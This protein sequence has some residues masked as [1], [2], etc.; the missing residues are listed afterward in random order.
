MAGE[1]SEESVS[2]PTEGPR[3]MGSRPPGRGDPV[4]NRGFRSSEA[5]P[6]QRPE[7]VGPTPV[8]LLW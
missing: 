5:H 2:G 6:I 3:A 7:K 8:C 1:P 4:A